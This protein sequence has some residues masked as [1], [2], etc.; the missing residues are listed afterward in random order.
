MR[1][2]SNN[3]NKKK[4]LETVK[5]NKI[6]KNKLKLGFKNYKEYSKIYSNIEIEIIKC[7]QSYAKFINIKGNEKF[8][9]H[10]YFNYDRYEI[11]I[12]LI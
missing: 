7:H 1:K 3:M 6:L 10:I 11:N 9:Y 8:F 12:Q 4:I 2:I 5:Y